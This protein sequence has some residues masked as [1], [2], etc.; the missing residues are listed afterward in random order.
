M[1]NGRKTPFLVSGIY[2][3]GLTTDQQ[4]KKRRKASLK[5]RT[6]KPSA[7]LRGG[8]HS[9]LGLVRTLGS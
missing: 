8:Q 2:F 9:C 1:P 7:V 3:G 5:Y 6:T 4:Q